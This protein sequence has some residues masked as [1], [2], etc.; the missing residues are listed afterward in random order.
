[1]PVLFPS[2]SDGPIFAGGPIFSA[3][4]KSNR[5]RRRRRHRHHRHNSSS[6]VKFIITS[7]TM[8]SNTI[9]ELIEKDGRK[10]RTASYVEFVATIGLG[11]P[12]WAGILLPLTLVYQ[13]GKAL[14]LS[15]GAVVQSKSSSSEEQ[16][17]GQG[18]NEN[19]NDDIIIIPRKDRK[20]DIVVL[21]ATGFTGGL[22]VRHLAKTYGINKDVKWAIAGR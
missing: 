10:T 12:F 1:M 2:S 4:S 18:K 11:L 19:E 5:R 21:G 6:N 14:V 13:S 8:E 20:Y 22:A 3:G 7:G 15:C 16:S 17:K 9:R